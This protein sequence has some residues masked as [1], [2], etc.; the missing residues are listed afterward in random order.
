VAGVTWEAANAYATWAGKRLPTEEEWEFAARG[1]DGR[2][3]PWGKNWV[4]GFANANGA[5]GGFA[6]VGT[7]KG[8]SP[9]GTFD[10]VGNVWE[11][12][13]TDLKAYVGGMLPAQVKDNVK[14]IRGGNYKSDVNSAT[15]TYRWWLLPVGDASQY[16]TTGFRCVKDVDAASPAQ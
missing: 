16:T 3:Y 15:T 14:V 5:S 10:M 6:D 8:E 2:L 11:W 12:T 9:Y 1:Q 4:K 7:Y 13:A